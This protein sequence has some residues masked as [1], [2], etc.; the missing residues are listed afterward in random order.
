[1][2]NTQKMGKNNGRGTLKYKVRECK[3][4]RPRKE[5]LEESTITVL[6]NLKG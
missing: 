6:N 4:F 3:T 1:M 5:S 2:Q